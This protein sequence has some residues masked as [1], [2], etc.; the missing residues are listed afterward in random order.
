MRLTAAHQKAEG[1]VGRS[2]VFCGAFWRTLGLDWMEGC[3]HSYE[4]G[5]GRSLEAQ[6]LQKVL[7]K[8]VGSGKLGGSSQRPPMDYVP[9]L[10]RPSEFEFPSNFL[11]LDI[12]IRPRQFGDTDPMYE[13]AKSPAQKDPEHP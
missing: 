4:A 1:E 13:E 3:A 11:R 7:S 2:V 10:L 8:T 6:A 5:Y 12:L 9:V